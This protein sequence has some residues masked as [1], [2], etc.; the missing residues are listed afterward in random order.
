MFEGTGYL[1]SAFG[2]MFVGKTVVTVP[3][4]AHKLGH[5]DPNI[6]L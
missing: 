6:C 2:V 4:N 5:E 3:A 1:E